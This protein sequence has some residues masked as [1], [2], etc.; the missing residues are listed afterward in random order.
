MTE[1]R[2]EAAYSGGAGPAVP[3]QYRQTST[4]S[5]SGWVG[6]AMFASTMMVL[7]G[8]FHIMQGLVALFDDGYF[9]V[10]D[11]G[12]TVSADYTAWGWTHLIGGA[13]VVIAGGCLFTGQTWARVVGVTCAVLSAII[14]FAF[15]AAYP[16]WSVIVIALDVFVILALTVHGRDITHADGG[17][18]D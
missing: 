6:W 18:Y 13:V 15:I 7:I 17:F 10:T 14:N 5:G 1:H 16:F 3:Q 8:F 12:L 11:N 4:A 9:L 2:T